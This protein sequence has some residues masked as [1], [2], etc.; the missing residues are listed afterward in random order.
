LM[1]SLVLALAWLMLPG[2]AAERH[3]QTLLLDRCTVSGIRSLLR[4]LQHS[5]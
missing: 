1:V 2:G 5:A 3:I 4:L